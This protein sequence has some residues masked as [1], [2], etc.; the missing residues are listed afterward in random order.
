[1]LY[2]VSWKILEIAVKSSVQPTLSYNLRV[3]SD[4]TSR[5]CSAPAPCY[6]RDRDKAKRDSRARLNG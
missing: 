6:Q 5:S 2:E 1:M 3:L 4:N